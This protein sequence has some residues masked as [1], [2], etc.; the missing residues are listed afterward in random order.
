MSLN[1]FGH[2]FLVSHFLDSGQVEQKSE[3]ASASHKDLEDSTKHISSLEKQMKIIKQ[4][5]E[6]MQKV[7]SYENSAL[8][9]C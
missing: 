5:R 2:L 6:D 1:V 8:Y 9:F 3:Q 4:E 7:H